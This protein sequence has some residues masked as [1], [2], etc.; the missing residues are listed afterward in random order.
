MI[1]L[2]LIFYHSPADVTYKYFYIYFCNNLKTAFFDKK[3]STV[4]KKLYKQELLRVIKMWISK[5]LIACR[6][7]QLNWICCRI[8]TLR[9]RF[10]K[11]IHVENAFME[12]EYFQLYIFSFHIYLVQS[13]RLFCAI[14]SCG[15]ILCLKI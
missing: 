13:F 4:M 15:C 14:N 2:Y 12:I 1:R 10:N 7:L 8:S 5:S 3:L 6:V 11:I 9:D